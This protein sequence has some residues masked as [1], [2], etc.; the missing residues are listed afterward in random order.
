MVCDTG[1]SMPSARSGLSGNARLISRRNDRSQSDDEHPAEY[2]CGYA[3]GNAVSGGEHKKQCA[4]KQLVG[5]RI[6]IFAEFGALAKRTRQ[7]SI[8]SVADSGQNE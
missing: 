6:E 7:H 1:L 3:P 2:D 4:D 5:N 8:E